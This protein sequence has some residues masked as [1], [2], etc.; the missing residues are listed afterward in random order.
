MKRGREGERERE[1]EGEREGK[2]ERRREVEGR[3][4]RGKGRDG[5]HRRVTVPH[6]A[7]EPPTPLLQNQRQHPIGCPC[8]RAGV[9]EADTSLKGAERASGDTK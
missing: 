3:R 8:Q 7:R 4:E 6:P 9:Q 5:P 2:G 1:K